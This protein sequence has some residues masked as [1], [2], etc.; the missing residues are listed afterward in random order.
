MHRIDSAEVGVCIY[1]SDVCIYIVH[2]CIYIV[3]VSIYIVDVCIYIVDIC[4]H[5]YFR[6]C[7]HRIDSAEV[8]VCVYTFV[9]GGTCMYIHIRLSINATHRLC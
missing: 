3:V 2:V 5:I 6:S 8:D 9:F 4:K 1:V 7:V